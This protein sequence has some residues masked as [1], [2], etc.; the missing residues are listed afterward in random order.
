M[1]QIATVKSSSLFTTLEQA[2]HRILPSGQ[3]TAVDRSC[4]LQATLI[5]APMHPD[6]A[7]RIRQ[8]FDRLQMGLLKIVD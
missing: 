7:D 1:T 8:V 2:T 5:D 4:L 6:Q 3:I